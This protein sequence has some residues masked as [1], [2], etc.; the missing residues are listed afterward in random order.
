MM[1][2]S[3]K[4]YSAPR[5][6]RFPTGG[7][8]TIPRPKRADPFFSFTMPRSSKPDLDLQQFIYLIASTGHPGMLKIGVANNLENR[9]RAFS[10]GNPGALSVIAHRQVNRVMAFQVERRV[11][12]HFRERAEGREWFRIT[13]EEVLPVIDGWTRKARAALRYHRRLLEGF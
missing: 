5:V 6:R 3:E 11:H 8:V 4:I 9:L 7:G 2:D 12:D 1:S 10:A 13:A